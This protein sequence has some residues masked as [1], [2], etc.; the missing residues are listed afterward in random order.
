[1]P[2]I[3]RE[4]VLSHDSLNVTAKSLQLRLPVYLRT[5]PVA[6]EPGEW[7]QVRDPAYQELARAGL[8][9]HGEPAEAIVDTLRLLAYATAEF[10]G[11]VATRQH[12]YYLHVG[13]HGPQ[14]VL[15]VL[16]NNRVLLR[17]VKSDVLV[18]QLLAE[19]PEAHPAPGRSMSASHDELKPSDGGSI[20]NNAGPRG[21]A[22]RL[23]T[24]FDKPRIAQGQLNT[25]IRV[26]VDNHRITSN[27]PVSFLDV[28]DGRWLSYATNNSGR[29]HY[30]A[31]PGHHDT[32]A[33]KLTELHQGLLAANR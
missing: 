17:P 20:Y 25:A 15:A 29:W 32:I 31:T 21:D 3:D 24:L 12:E 28:D 14:A 9:A 33:S 16:A 11:L 6:Y 19:L 4:V 27:E 23:L 10:Y 7:E 13:G 5:E 22:R 30:A 18:T 2:V 26:G 1:M 8:L